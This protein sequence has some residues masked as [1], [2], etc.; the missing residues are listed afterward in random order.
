MSLKDKRNERERRER[1]IGTKDHRRNEGRERDR[2]G[3]FPK[4]IY[5]INYIY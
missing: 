5:I 1:S 4:Y 3:N 2:E